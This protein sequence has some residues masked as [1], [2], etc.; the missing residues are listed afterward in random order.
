MLIR[1]FDSRDTEAVVALWASCG[2][3]RPWN[4]PRRDIERK[5]SVQPELFLVGEVGEA[6]A[7][8]AMAGY[9]GHRGW[10]NYLAVD[11]DLRRRG[12]ARAMM[13]EIE[14]MLFALGCPKI[15][16][17]VR[18]ANGDALGFYR[19][20]GYSVDPVTSLGRRLVADG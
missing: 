10:I 13:A 2:L 6:I 12:H 4:D 8:T 18:D 9:D 20:L 11:P 19:S 3:K 17:Q 16:L 1:A 14:R 5:L 15:N 7:A